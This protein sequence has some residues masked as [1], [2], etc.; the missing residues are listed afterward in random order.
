[1][2]SNAD[3]SIVI[4]TEL[5]NSGFK[6]GEGKLLSAINSLVNK[7]DNI[8]ESVKQSFSGM[9]P[10]LQGIARNTE[11]IYS[12]MASNGQQAAE[13]NR[14]VTATQ[15]EMAQTTAQAT[16]QVQQQ[17]QAISGLASQSG[18]AVSSV[19]SLER[20]VNSLSANM[21]SISQSA[22]LGF[23]NGNAVLAF[24]SKLT[25]VEQKLDAA[26]Q[27]LEAF[28]N[29]RIPTEDFTWLEQNIAKAEAQLNGYIEKQIQMENSG[30]SKRSSRWKNLQA[31]IEQTTLMLKTYK[32]EMADLENSGEAFTLGSDTQQ[33]AQMQQSLQNTEA[34]LQRNR[35]LIDSE[36]IAQARLNVLAA[37]EQVA[38]AQTTEQQKK[39]LAQLQQA[40]EQLREAA[41]ASS[42]GGAE[43]PSSETTT[44]WQ[45]FGSILKTVASKAAKVT[46]TLAKISFHAV[47]AGAKKAASA[48]RSF[49]GQSRNTDAS[50]KSLVRT[51]RSLKN[52]MI[53]R[54]K[55]SFISS[56]M[57]YTKNGIQSLAK[58]SSS[59]DKSMSNIIN[60]AKQLGGNL[61]VSMGNLISAVGPV[62]TKIINLLSTAINYINAFFALL[63]G[64]KTMTVAKKSTDSYAASV[65]GAAEKQKELNR[66]VY[67][68]DELNKRNKESSSGSGGSGSGGGVNYEEVPIDSIL[69][70]SV[71]NFFQK[72]KDAITAG[73]WYEVGQIIADGLNTGM[74][75]VDDWI[76]NTF[77]PMGVKWARIIATVLNGLV[78]GFNWKLLGKTIADGINAAFD[79][80]NTFL[81]TFNFENLG[82]GVGNAINSFFTHTD[83]KLIG[84]TIANGIMAAVNFAYGVITTVDFLA[85]GTHIADLLNSA[86]KTADFSRIGATIGGALRGAIQA[87]FGFVESIDFDQLSEKIKAAAQSFLDQMN[88]VDPR[89]GLNGW[90]ELGTALA[91][92]ANGIVQ[93]F[94]SLPWGEIAKGIGQTISTFLS[95][96]DIEVKLAL[97][98]LIITKIASVLLGSA[99]AKG[100]GQA[101]G[102]K[103]L[104]SLAG[105]W[106]SLGGKLKGALSSLGTSLSAFATT[107]VLA[108]SAGQIGA[109][110]LSGLFIGGEIGKLLDNHV[111]GPLI[112]AL[113]GDEVTAEL[114]KNFHW[115]GEGGFFDE[116]WDGSDTFLGNVQ[117]WGDALG[118]M[119]SDAWSG[120]KSGA[121][122]AWSGIKSGLSGA[123]DGIKTAASG[124]WSGI[125]SAVS[126]AWSGVKS[127]VSGVAENVKTGL[128]NTWSNVKSTASSA[129]GNVKTT[130]T[131]AF[132]NAKTSLSTTASNIKSNLS[133]AWSNVKSNTSSAWSN[134]KST[135]STQFTNAKAT[136]SSTASNIK[137]NL[138][139]TWSNVKS[140]A[141]QSWSSLKSSV[142]STF[143]NLKSSLTGTAGNIKSSISSTWSSVKSTASSKWSDIKSTV[144]SKWS[145]LKETLKAH[146]WT[147][148]G[149]NLVSGLKSGISN[150]W[151]SLTSSVGSL[152]SS[153]LS[154]CKSAF[155]IH[156]PSK[157]MAEIGAYLD[158]GMQQGIENNQGK[159]LSTA[160]NLA[161]AVTEGMTPN[162]PEI[163]VSSAETVNGIS[164]IADRLSDIAGQFRAIA[165]M[166]ASMGG[167]RTPEIAQGTV[168]PYKTKIDTSDTTPVEFEAFKTF[169][170]DVDERM[171]D[172]IYVLRQI[173]EAI[174]KLNLNIDISA[175]ERAITKQKRSH[176]L[177]FGGA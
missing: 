146:D 94:E 2:A 177:N 28:G 37:Q 122:T 172:E 174:K 169:S 160:K 31:Q 173:L 15:A 103:I 149:T 66:Q 53:S 154:K 13:A 57:E 88:A 76:N 132:T 92:A 164:L 98:A 49:A 156:S 52:M 18:C 148:I 102:G 176:D 112:E 74:Q 97:G 30:T 158:A 16:Q 58:F 36:A 117:T 175:L 95:K 115:F 41:A 150:A 6:A 116:M 143:T 141:T 99:V 171:A 39:A 32:S 130:V 91:D 45:R 55:Y 83:W 67:G 142:S 54:L 1:M 107:D 139:S 25:A 5:D 120:I 145:S 50:A 93:A 109:A 48:M 17:G 20:E 147:S 69:P 170:S 23:S 33:Y 133:S 165:D 24:D 51:L 166:L 73:N 126:G 71:Q 163:D 90:Q 46:A 75:I 82:K 10:V 157:K 128:A 81:T 29:T 101:L 118:M 70:E 151:S 124:A 134:V 155:G 3:G 64:K 14:E 87:A 21:Q 161:S 121:S 136:L 168:V 138:S 40:Q 59:F 60:S 47:A 63:S 12:L 140:N 153:L 56:I 62:I 7:I 4:D 27:K 42:N 110:I 96:A 119:F 105:S 61:A 100:I 108:A 35:S 131:T 19:S 123:W 113:G 65:G 85:I 86:I 72:L 80:A 22:E 44:G 26:K 9:V 11:G 127:G 38:R 167:L 137:S 84:R 34:V 111:I 43:A 106:P 104:G 78:D 8:G 114:Y 162:S 68:F 129:W 89:T 79:I 125:S 135:I 159:V 144:S 152:C 77:R